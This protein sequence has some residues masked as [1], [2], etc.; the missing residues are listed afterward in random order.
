MLVHWNV[1]FLTCWYGGISS[2]REEFCIIKLIHAVTFLLLFLCTC[3]LQL[4]M[5]Q[6]NNTHLEIQYYQCKYLLLLVLINC[7]LLPFVTWHMMINMGEG[8]REERKISLVYWK[9]RWLVVD[10]GY[11]TSLVVTW[12]HS[13]WIW[14]SGRCSYHLRPYACE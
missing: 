7:T 13:G 3:I 2:L 8:R 6:I 9:Q 12:K 4:K 11:L 14:E 10:M 1:A 5:V